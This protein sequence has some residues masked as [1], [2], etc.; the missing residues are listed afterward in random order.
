MVGFKPLSAIQQVVLDNKLLAKGT[1]GSEF[2]AGLDIKSKIRCCAPAG[3]LLF[4]GQN[5]S[6]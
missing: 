1:R 3:I 5:H 4:L 2:L 6:R